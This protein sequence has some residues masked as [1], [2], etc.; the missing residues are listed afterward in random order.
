[1]TEAG[2]GFVETASEVL[3]TMEE[4]TDEIR[5]RDGRL[6]GKICVAMPDTIGHSLFI[7]LIDYFGRHHPSVELRVMALHPNSIPLALTTGD[8]EVGVV[9]SAHRQAGVKTMPLAFEDLHLVGAG[10]KAD[11]YDQNRTVPKA[12]I[13]LEEVAAYPLLLPAIQPGLRAIIDAAFAQR[14]LLPNVIL[15]VDA[16]DAIIEL[17]SSGRAFSI[18]NFAGVQRF[19]STG[20]LSAS[21]IVD[22]PIQRL[23]STAVPEN[24]PT[25]RL[26]RAVEQAIGEL[27]VELQTEARWAPQEPGPYAAM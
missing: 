7:P 11:G 20:L 3:R 19:V 2:I 27:T 24:R 14:Q 9:S 5:S 25:T 18:M 15:D 23:L 8:A 26:M 21:R 6:V 17:V 4:V 16:E 22:S 10:P 1:M 12:D 13:S